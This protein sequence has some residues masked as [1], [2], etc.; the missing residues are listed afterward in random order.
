MSEFWA[1]VDAE[2]GPARGHT[3]VRDHVLGELGHRT[4]EQAL[5]A[6]E[7]PRRVWWAL[8]EDLE[9]SPGRRWGPDGPAR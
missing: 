3:L 7:D 4:A 8:C 5:R 9:V 1:L 6:G 2:F